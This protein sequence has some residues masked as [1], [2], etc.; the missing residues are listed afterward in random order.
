MYRL[1][2]VSVCLVVV[3]LG[4][5]LELKILVSINIGFKKDIGGGK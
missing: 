4:V 1:F 5:L 3:Y 2:I